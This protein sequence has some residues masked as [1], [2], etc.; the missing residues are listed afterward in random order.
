MRLVRVEVL[1]GHAVRSGLVVECGH[2]LVQVDH[3]HAGG[4]GDVARP[5]GVVL[6]PDGAP[7][8]PDVAGDECAEDGRGALRARVGDVL[9]QV[10]AEGVYRLAPACRDRRHVAGF[11]A[12][13]WQRASGAAR[14]ER[15]DVVVAELDEDI[16]AGRHVPQR[17]LPEPF[18]LERATAPAAPRA[19]HYADPRWVE[20]VRDGRTPA[21]LARGRRVYGRVADQQQR[22]SRGRFG[23]GG[24]GD[25][26]ACRQRQE[27]HDTSGNPLAMAAWTHDS[28][29]KRGRD[30]PA[31][32]GPLSYSIRTSGGESGRPLT[33]FVLIPARVGELSRPRINAAALRPSTPRGPD[34]A[35]RRCCGAGRD[36]TGPSCPSGFPRTRSRCCLRR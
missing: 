34:R 15:A 23:R 7:V 21:E 19:V 17:F 28:P 30:K 25:G 32:A 6:G 20:V 13:A 9:A 22:G 36:S 8:F 31:G 24:G 1:P 33:E 2:R 26:G 35:G 27:H 4:G 12:H 10:P 5:D 16:V 29:S 18:G 3:R 11:L 14:V